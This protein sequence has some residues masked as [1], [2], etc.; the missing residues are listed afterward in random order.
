MC[1]SGA[2]A[3]RSMTRSSGSS[4]TPSAEPAMSSKAEADGLAPVAEGA[5]PGPR[6]AFSLAWRLTIWHS[7]SAFVVVVGTTAFLYLA[8]VARFAQTNDE[9]ILE[10][11]QIAR[12]ML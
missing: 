7:A 11:V 8:Q 6:R 4:S 3:P 2:C 9:F 10:H 1:T 12:T 5:A